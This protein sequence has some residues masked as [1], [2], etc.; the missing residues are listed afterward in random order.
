MFGKKKTNQEGWRLLHVTKSIVNN[1]RQ[2]THT[3]TH[4]PLDFM[5]HRFDYS[6]FL[7][8]FYLPTPNSAGL[9]SKLAYTQNTDCTE[10]THITGLIKLSIHNH[11][12][13]MHLTLP[14]KPLSL[15]SVHLYSP[16]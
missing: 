2:D 12:S 13:Q 5:P 1:L 9:Y 11:Y 7:L 8:S 14:G 4:T 15:Y 10:E 6:Y 16:Q 3:H